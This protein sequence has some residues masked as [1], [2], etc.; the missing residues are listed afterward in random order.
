MPT[1]RLPAVL[2]LAAAIVG[3]A[4]V[5]CS[6]SGGAGDDQADAGGDADQELRINDVQVLASHN[7]YHVQPEPKLLDALHDFLGDGA[8]GFEYTHRPLAEELDA[9]V[10][11]VELDV[12]VDD[13]DGGRYASPKLVPA[14]GVEPPDPAMAEPGLKV[15]HVQEVDFR[16]T[17]PQFVDCLTQ[18]RDWSEDHPDHLPITIQIE[19]KD[20]PVSD[21]GLGFVTPLPWTTDAYAALEDEVRSVFDDDAIITP[22]DVKGDHDTLP[23]AVRADA[24]PTLAEARGK[25]M[26]ALDDSGEER[27]LY[28]QLHPNVEDRLIF[29]SAEPPDDDAGFVVVN[30][31]VADGDHIRELV[32]DGFI[33]RSRA[34]ADTVEARSGDTTVQEAAWASGAQFVST[35]YPFPDEEFGTGYVAEVPGPGVVRCNPVRSPA[36]CPADGI[37]P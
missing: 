36:A 37:D 20:D 4:G 9:G 8:D 29:V 33:V 35:D 34:D 26:F 11:Q 1:R 32:T 17:C 24:W 30:D 16:S 13:P 27:E 31:P 28:R 22:A 12:F 14:L 7:S 5:A 21:P 2:L 18:L 6:D 3:A 15:F 25:V 23:E 10:R 19:P